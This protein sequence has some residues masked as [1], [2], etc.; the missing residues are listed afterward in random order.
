[1]S[2]KTKTAEEIWNRV[3]TA[4]NPEWSE[5]ERIIYAME[6]YKNQELT[7]QQE[8][9]AELKNKLEELQEENHETRIA[10]G[11]TIEDNIE[12]KNQNEELVEALKDANSLIDSLKLIITQHVDAK[13]SN[14]GVGLSL[15]LFQRELNKIESYQNTPPKN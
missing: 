1:M 3:S 4:Y 15:E 9:N 14:I 12:L 2:D 6:E 11:T 8:I 10:H 5:S 13:R 7:Q